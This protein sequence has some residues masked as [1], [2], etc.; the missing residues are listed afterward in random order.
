MLFA[1]NEQSES[2]SNVVSQSVDTS[3]TDKEVDSMVEQTSV[4]VM[5]ETALASLKELGH[6][7]I[8]KQE[9][10][11]DAIKRHVKHLREALE[12]TGK[13]DGVRDTHIDENVVKT[14][15]LTEESVSTA[16]SAIVQVNEAVG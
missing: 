16:K 11:T 10:A 15:T 5:I 13:E 2:V 1:G 3:L 7:A 8:A 12:H 4:E 6:K 9:Q 14:Q